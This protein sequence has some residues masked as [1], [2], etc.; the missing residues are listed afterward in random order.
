M[1]SR[2]LQSPLQE[3]QTSPIVLCSYAD[4][5]SRTQQAVP[6]AIFDLGN[7]ALIT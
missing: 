4:L 3:S 5:Y 7:E 6:E 1:I 2:S